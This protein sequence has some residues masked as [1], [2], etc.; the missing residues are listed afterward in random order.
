MAAPIKGPVH[1]LAIKT[2]KK[3]V[4]KEF[5]DDSFEK[6]SKNGTLKGIRSNKKNKIKTKSTIIIK[7]KRGD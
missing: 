1:G 6:V 4:K 5:N 7:T 3:P 2:A